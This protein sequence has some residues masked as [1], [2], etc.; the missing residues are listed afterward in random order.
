MLLATS[1]KIFLCAFQSATVTDDQLLDLTNPLDT[2]LPVLSKLWP[3]YG[4]MCKVLHELQSTRSTLSTHAAAF[5]D[6]TGAYDKS[7]AFLN[8]TELDK[9]KACRVT[10]AAAVG[11][12]TALDEVSEAARACTNNCNV[13]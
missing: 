8:L 1:K 2:L 7:L 6:A 13:R 12:V 9:I 5:R 10:L 3:D 11:A 4:F